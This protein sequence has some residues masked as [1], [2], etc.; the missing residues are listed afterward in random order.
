VSPSNFARQQGVRGPIAQTPQISFPV[1]STFTFTEKLRAIQRAQ[2]SSLCVGLDV[3][4]RRLP[5]D[6]TSD[7]RGV[8]RFVRG[9]VEATADLVCAYKPNLAFFE[10]MGEP[11]FGILKGALA[12]VPPGVITIADGKRG[13]IG[14]T[15]ER[16]AAALFEVLGFDAATLNPYQGHDSL[17]PYLADRTRGG[18]VLCK[19][20]NP[21]SDDFQEL[22]CEV[23]GST[24][25]LYEIVARRAVEWNRL[26]NIGL[27]VGATFPNQ[28]SRVRSL[29]P[30]LPILIPGVG[31]Q[32]GDAAES[33]QRGAAADGTLAVVNV[34]RQ[35]LYA[36]S[37]ADWAARARSEAQELR[38][39][40]RAAGPG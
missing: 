30:E 5:A 14:T 15:A 29:A 6:L 19:T 28:L 20:S 3:D 22:I 11:G 27:V 21:G 39:A 18:F 36:S 23:E 9:I 25:P 38:D 32:G 12:A 17:E 7:A 1:Q 24:A 4:E 13:D 33:I 16:Y 37:G 34:A 8:E 26:G 40:M 35:V 10:A 2:G 31:T